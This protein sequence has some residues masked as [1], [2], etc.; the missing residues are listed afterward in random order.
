MGNATRF[1]VAYHDFRLPKQDWLHQTRNIRSAILIVAIGVD[2]DVC[3]SAEGEIKAA[4]KAARKPVVR[5][6]YDYVMDTK[7]SR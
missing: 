5:G 4:R 6:I 7:F 2:D 1:A 3:A